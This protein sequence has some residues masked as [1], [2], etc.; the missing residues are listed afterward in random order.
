M[1]LTLFVHFRLPRVAAASRSWSG[2]PCQRREVHTFTP[3]FI[4]PRILDDDA[5]LAWLSTK[6]SGDLESGDVCCIVLVDWIIQFIALRVRNLVPVNRFGM[7]SRAGASLP[8][9]LRCT[10]LERRLYPFCHAEWY[11]AA[12]L[13]LDCSTVA[14]IS[15]P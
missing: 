1:D 9:G 6:L 5:P 2:G 13:S 3:R 15:L 8:V 10:L 12:A 14:S 4:R 11:K 7:L